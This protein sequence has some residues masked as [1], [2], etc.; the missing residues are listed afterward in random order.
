MSTNFFIHTKKHLLYWSQKQ[1][2]LF[3][4]IEVGENIFHFK[5]LLL[6]LQELVAASPNQR[7][8]KGISIA[9][10]VIVA[11]LASVAIAV[12]IKTPEEK[13]PRVSGSRFGIEHILDQRFSPPG[14]NGSWISG[15]IHSCSIPG[16]FVSIDVSHMY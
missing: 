8:W 6:S 12:Y 15:T 3:V 11:I 13:E 4:S 10:F 2:N 16:F 7:N 14:F 1:T 5:I 9:I